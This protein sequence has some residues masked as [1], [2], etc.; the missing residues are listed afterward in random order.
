M[1]PSRTVLRSR[2]GWVLVVALLP[3][4]A[5]VVHADVPGTS[6][7]SLR[8]DYSAWREQLDHNEFQAPLYLN[9]KQSAEKLAGELYAVMPVRT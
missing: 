3:A 8:A 7:S 4:S 1:W 6:D 2:L 5:E 9:S